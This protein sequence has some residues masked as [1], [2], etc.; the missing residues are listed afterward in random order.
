MKL[1]NDTDRVELADLP[2]IPGLRARHLQ[3]AV[4]YGRLAEV[5]GAANAFDS[6]PWLPTGENLQVEY[7][8]NDGID[9]RRD[10]V[11]AEVDDRL[12]AFS[13][14]ERTVR[15]GVATY[16]VSGW[17]HPEH[18]RRGLGTCL[19]AWNLRRAAARAASEPPGMPV[20]A[21]AFADEGEAGHRALLAGAG[22]EPARHFFLMQRAR[23]D[24]VPAAPLPD[25]IEVRPV[26]PDQHRTIFDAESEA[27]LD[28][29]GSH[30]W[31]DDRFRTTF[32]KSEL[33]TSLWVVAWDG[34]Q[35]AGVVENWVWPDENRKLGVKRAWLERISVRRPWRRRGLGRAITAASL[36]RLREA[37]LDEAM[38]GVDS[39]NPNGALGLYESLGFA[40]YLRAAAYR[41]PITF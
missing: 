13:G 24:D 3:E 15:D 26:T 11:L 17:V 14:V 16:N 4:D 29:W 39:E 18:R 41:R 8:G 35:V 6:I 9:P 37:G 33:D 30:E 23:L 19:L 28:H 12:V 34:D 27:F 20:A 40:V 5:M 25:G 38:L 22:F 32:A 2:R 21:Q 36:V 10:L 7:E 1:Q 31:G